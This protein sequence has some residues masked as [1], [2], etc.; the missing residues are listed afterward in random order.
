MNDEKE[1]LRLS[2]SDLLNG[3]QKEF[4]LTEFVTVYFSDYTEYHNYGIY[5]ALIPVS[6]KNDVLL[7][8]SWDLSHGGGLPG[9]VV[10]HSKGEEQVKY[11]RF[12]DDNG[13]EPLIFDLNF[14][15]MRDDYLEISEEFRHFHHLFHDIKN[16]NY[17]KFDDDGNEAIVAIVEKNRIQIR[18]KEIR[19]FLS[20]K[21]MYLSIQFDCREHSSLTLDNIGLKKGGDDFKTKHM[22]WG[23]HYGEFAGL[24]DCQ[25]FSRLVGKRLIE[26]LHKSKSGVY[27][28]ADEPLKKYVEFIVNIDDVGDEFLFTSNPNSLSNYFGANPDA[29]NY[30]TPIHFKKQVLEKYF[31]Q[32][33]KYSVEDSY[34]RC[35]SLWGL[36][37]DN[38]HDNKVCVWLGDLGR[39]L[40]YGEQLHW[41]SYNIPPEGGV[42]KTFFKRQIAAQFADSDRPEHLFKM[43]YNELQ[44]IC[45]EF[46]GWKILLPLDQHD[47][48]YFACLR[49]PSTNEQRDFDEQI[50]SLTKILI[51]SINEKKL[52]M[53]LKG[54]ISCEVDGSINK[55]EQVLVSI[56]VEDYENHI[57]FLRKL[58]NLRSSSTA[59]RKGGNYQKI[60]KEFGI[61][62]HDLISVFKEILSKALKLLD[63]LIGLVREKKFS[64]N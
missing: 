43:K 27:G 33:S 51:D 8:P 61:D 40:P 36:Q 62:S 16:N 23:L 34:L 2:Q 6:Q 54:S 38:H 42:S 41:R 30:L 12:G 32:P 5:C 59:H 11:F 4:S 26:P 22:C 45:D 3:F 47:S 9:S 10:Y 19:Q 56:G 1:K 20:I 15:G 31:Q 14:Y 28:F 24:S 52:N 35:G 50:L 46:L 21:E 39:D 55:L 64:E 37:M 48:H 63:F 18:A 13:I 58:Q 60:A 25:S 17:I 49:I 57:A 7:N 44:K 53:L 29:P